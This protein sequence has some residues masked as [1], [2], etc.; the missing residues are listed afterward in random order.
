MSTPLIW[1]VF[2]LAFAL[3]LIITR[4]KPMLSGILASAFSLLLALAA[5]AAAQDAPLGRWKTIDDATGKPKSV[6]EI[7]RARDG[8]LAGRVVDIL[9]LKDGPNPPCKACKGPLHGKPIRGLVILW[10]LHDGDF[11]VDKVRH[12]VLEPV[13][14]NAVIGVDHGDHFSIWRGVRNEVIQRATLEAG[15]GG[16]VEEFET[17]AQGGAVVTHRLPHGRVFGVVV[18]QQHFEVRIVEV[19]QRVKRL[20]NH[21]GRLVVTGHM[22]R[23][24]RS[25]GIVAFDR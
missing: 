10:G 11:R 3:L 4:K 21:L 23:D 2:P 8:S 5:P 13:A 15:Q 20:F 16:D 14:I 24:F 7:H 1:I 12:H 17:R 19:G 9:D 22:N 25:V 18:D 6:V